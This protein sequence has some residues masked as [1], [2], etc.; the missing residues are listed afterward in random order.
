MAIAVGRQRLLSWSFP[1]SWC[2]AR[3]H[4][5][6]RVSLNREERRALNASTAAIW[7]LF[8]LFRDPPLTR[9]DPPRACAL[10]ICIFGR[11]FFTPLS[12]P[13]NSYILIANRV[14]DVSKK[15]AYLHLIFSLLLL[16]GH[17]LTS[18]HTHIL[19]RRLKCRPSKY[20]QRNSPRRY[21]WTQDARTGTPQSYS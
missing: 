19:V 1:F 16:Y 18:P 7:P 8:W 15:R 4:Q 21:A 12:T 6:A 10:F 13:R 2:I 5:H 3:R 14:R 9:P 17:S 20:R 11:F